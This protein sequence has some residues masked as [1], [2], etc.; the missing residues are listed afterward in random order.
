M[1]GNGCRRRERPLRNFAKERLFI[2]FVKSINFTKQ[3]S[4]ISHQKDCK[5]PVNSASR[6]SLKLKPVKSI[7]TFQ[8]LGAIFLSQCTF[9]EKSSDLMTP[10]KGQYSYQCYIE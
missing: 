9:S 3:Q 4:I 10:K 2:N 8:E 5:L 1:R 7:H 6:F